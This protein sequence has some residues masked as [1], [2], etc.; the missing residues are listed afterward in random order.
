MYSRSIYRFG[1]KP[2]VLEIDLPCHRFTTSL[3]DQTY[4]V[5]SSEVAKVGE[6]MGSPTCGA[7]D[8]SAVSDEL[9]NLRRPGLDV[10][11]A[12]EL[13]ESI[14]SSVSERVNKDIE[15]YN[16]KVLADA[17]KQKSIDDVLSSV[18]NSATVS[19]GTNN[20]VDA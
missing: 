3:T 17:E 20:S 8:N 9:V 10:T 19:L 1:R 5:V 18:A 12:V 13:V 4:Y 6:T 14:K 7:Y 11:E 15:D 16:A 2:K